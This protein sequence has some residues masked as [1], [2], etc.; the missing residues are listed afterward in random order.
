[1]YKGLLLGTWEKRLSLDIKI[2][3][4]SKRKGAKL[5][6]DFDLKAKDLDEVTP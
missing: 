5:A 2:N 1:M 3:F 4:T 6:P